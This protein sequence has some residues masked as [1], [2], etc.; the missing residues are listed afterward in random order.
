MQC[1]FVK[2]LQLYE[3]TKT[4]ANEHSKNFYVETCLCLK[5][6]EKCTFSVDLPLKQTADGL[7]SNQSAFLHIL[8]RDALAIEFMLM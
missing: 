2:Y 5:S 3:I 7:S 8:D 1:C 6:Q 4:V